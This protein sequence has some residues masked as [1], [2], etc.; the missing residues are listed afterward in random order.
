MASKDEE[1][2]AAKAIKVSSKDELSSLLKDDLV[3]LAKQHGVK[4]PAKVLKADLV[5]TLAS[6]LFPEEVVVKPKPFLQISESEALSL[7]RLKLEME[8]D[9]LRYEHEREEREREREREREKEKYE[10][11]RLQIQAQ[12]PHTATASASNPNNNSTIHFAVKLLPKLLESNVEDFFLAFERLAQV[13]NWDKNQWVPIIQTQFSG[14]TLKVFNEIPLVDA[15]KYDI[16]KQTIL[17]AFQLTP[18]VYRK[19]F[20]DMRK[21]ETQTFSDFIFHLSN[22]FTRWMKS[23]DALENIDTMINA[24]V[25]EQLLNTLPSDLLL[26]SADLKVAKVTDLAIALDSYV[27]LRGSVSSYRATASQNVNANYGFDQNKSHDNSKNANSKPY[28]N[29]QYKT[30]S[31]Q[32]TDNKNENT[33]QST[34]TDL[35]KSQLICHRCKKIGHIARYCRSK[36][37]DIKPNSPNNQSLS[38][39]KPVNLI[40]E[41]KLDETQ[42]LSSTQIDLNETKVKAVTLVSDN[43]EDIHPLFRPYCQTGFVVDSCGIRHPICSLRDTAALQSLIRRSS[44]PQSAYHELTEVRLIKGIGDQELEVSMIEFDVELR[45]FSG[46]VKAG[47]VDS[48]PSGVDFLLANDI[49]CKFSEVSDV[50]VVTRSM[51]K[52]VIDSLT[53]D[54]NIEGLFK[55][56]DDVHIANSTSSDDGNEQLLENNGSNVVEASSSSQSVSPDSIDAQ[57]LLDNTSLNITREKLIELQNADP[58]INR[59][60]QQAVTRPYSNAKDYFLVT[61]RLLMHS[62]IDKKKQVRSNRIVIPSMLISKVLQLAHDVPLSGHLGFKKTCKRIESFFYWPKF[63]RVVK[64][65]IRSCDMCQRLDK[66]HPKRIAPLHPLPIVEEPFRRIIMDVVGPLKECPGSGNRFILT[67][68]DLATH[69]PIAIPL[70]NH[71]AANICTALM[72]VFS[73]FGF[74]MEVQTDRGSDFTSELMKYFLEMFGIKHIKAT[75]YHPESQ[76]QVERFHRCLKDMLRAV[77]DRFNGDWDK[78]I[79][80]VLFAYR[81]I[82]VETTG[83]S[84]F[85]LMYT[86]PIRGPL[87]ILHENWTI[88]SKTSRPNII[89]FMLDVREKFMLGRQMSAENAKRCRLKSKV[90]YDIKARERKFEIGDLVLAL[91]PKQGEPLDIS[92]KGPFKILEKNGDLNYLISTNSKRYP[93]RLCHVNM[94]K[95][96]YVRDSVLMNVEGNNEMEMRDHEEDFLYDKIL[97]FEKPEKQSEFNLKHLDPDKRQELSLLL[98][99]Y[100][101]LFSDIPGKTNLIEHSIKVKPNAKPIKQNPYRANPIKAQV[102]KREIEEMLQMSIISESSSNWASPI[103]LVDKPDGSVRFVVDY[104]KVNEISETDAFP[105]PRVDDLIELIGKANIITKIDISKAFWQIPLSEESKTISSFI[106]PFGLYQFNVMPF[107]LIAAGNT[108]QRLMKKVLEGLQ[109]FAWAYLD[110]IVIFSENWEEHLLHV[111]AVFDR[112]QSAGLTIKKTKCEFGNAVVTYLGHTVGN[113]KIT[114]TRAKI[115]SILNFPKPKDVKQLRQFLGVASYYRRYVPHMAHIVAPLTNMLKKGN[116]FM[117]DDQTHTAFL[118]I[119]SILASNP[120][121]RPPDYTKD[122]QIGV[123]ASDLAIGAVLGQMYGDTF[124]PVCYMSKR[125]NKH[126]SRYSTIEK[127]C[128]ALLTAVRY[129]AVYFS[130]SPVLIYTDHNPLQ[131]LQKM[132]NHN[133]KLLRWLLEL[134]QYNLIIKYKPGKQNIL[135]DL[136]SRPALENE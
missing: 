132:V 90:W 7:E 113:N 115:D 29:T 25:T 92:W 59:L 88:G 82:P 35:E 64:S 4:D 24:I 108:F 31:N 62:H 87:S 135:P 74:P 61:D 94:I 22:T 39:P 8:R 40:Q 116:K 102:I 91:L 20:R 55:S 127:E 99:K 111:Q 98:N 9:R 57:E 75:A 85:E 76:A 119:K 1:M 26:Y 42:V 23:I 101:A 117:W 69:Y 95:P 45:E 67:L 84:P 125:L 51:T 103:I 66:K 28:K 71:T 126:Q 89:Q 96:Y 129:F 38:S 33:G 5:S 56:D 6:I 15:I 123:D 47:T 80:Y 105:L 72:D 133:R 107:G 27:S 83:F 109:A 93:N 104:R 16:V 54:V 134:Q 58:K 114:P 106:T 97:S 43:K 100:E 10:L 53:H 65:Y 50:S 17:R 21:S 49:Y 52:T 12:H 44:L 77:N 19:R 79:P 60:F 41:S 30:K 46:R 63:Y 112:I 81:E 68:I 131:F 124:H 32:S 128:F 86:Y 36:W 48:L 118:E 3:V 37:N 136:L 70:K 14:K 122:F 78:A 2:Q 34:R 121:L 120:I 130:G 11:Q 18:H 13:Q 110:D 73:N